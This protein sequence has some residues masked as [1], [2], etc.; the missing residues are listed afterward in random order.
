MPFIDDLKDIQ[1]QLATQELSGWLL[2]DFRRSNSLACTFLD[3]PVNQ[4]LTRRFF[5]WIPQQGDPVKIVSAIESHVLDH[6][7][8]SKSIYRSWQEL[9]QFLFAIAVEHRRIAMEYSPYN[10]LPVVSQVDAGTVDLIR[11]SGAEVVSSANLIQQ[12]TSVWTEEQLKS[13][14]EAAKALEEIV[15]LAWS[16]IARA[17]ATG[18]FVTEYD[19]QQFMLEEIHKRKCI[20]SGDPICAVNKH[21]ANPHYAP[22]KQTALTIYHGD[23]ILLDVWCKQAKPGA[24]YADISRVGVALD[25]P[26]DLQK[27]IFTI[28][29]KARD[30]ATEFVRR[31][32]AA[33]QLIEG[34]QVDQLCRDVITQEGYGEFFIH[35]TGHNI[36]EED[37]GLGANLDNL[38]THDF[39]HLLPGTCFSIEPGIYLPDQF[40]VRLE[41]DVYLHPSG[42]IDV[43]GGIQNHLVRL[44]S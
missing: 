15:D 21:S 32:H 18:S 38:E 41:Y 7:P 14:L 23:F 19:V 27:K 43:T 35:R 33:H 40:G 31:H 9:E 30:E 37:H 4:M 39:R 8:G 42:E 11:R 44:G 2:Y 25:E 5:Y 22:Q 17:L 24:V 26:T 10:A 36:G 6:L 16:F 12:Y 20:T 1:H 3:I 29:K 34:W 28:V 13:H